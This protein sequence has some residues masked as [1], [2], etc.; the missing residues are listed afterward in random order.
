MSRTEG[1][2]GDPDAVIIGSGPNGLVAACML[3]RAGLD[4]LVL[5]A[6]PSRAGGAVGSEEATRPGFVH[7]VGAGFF[8]WGSLSPAFRNLPLLEHGLRWRWADFESCHPAPDGSY[9]CIAR[10]H[11]RT[12]EH[13]GSPADGKRWRRAAIWYASIEPA[14][15]DLLLRSFPALGAAVRLGPAH[16]ARL[17]S[18]F[19]SSGRGLSERWFTSAAARRVLPSLALHVDVGPDDRFGAALGFMLGMTATTGGYAVPEGGARWIT[20]AL[21]GC[22]QSYGGR[23]RLGARVHQIVVHGGR[24]AAVRITG[25]EEIA[26]RVILADT[27]VAALLLDLVGRQHVPA[28]VADFVRH[29]PRGWGT[30]KVDWAL[31]GAVPWSVE[32]ARASAVV[33][34]GDSVDDLSRFTAAVRAGSLPNH[35]YVV[36]GQQSLADPTRAPPGCHALWA[37]TRV[38]SLIEGG[39][40][41]Q[42]ERHA[43]RIDARIEELAP[44]FRSLILARRVVSPDQLQAMDANLVGGDLGGGSNAWHRQL[45]FRPV[46]PYFRY[47]MPVDGLYLCSS[48]AHPGAGVHG[49]CGFNAA[50]RVLKDLA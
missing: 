30:L 41:A 23:V 17:A 16:L 39:W 8:P 13:F 14:V 49:M 22:L 20:N 24:A 10:D 44:G 26:A 38:P 19:A 25:G 37:Y 35:P 6:H 9:A 50:E 46:F 15:I 11:D 27:D 47:R 3:A 12:A 33:H 7:D 42:A 31:D 21:V 32:A 28:R 40:A 45:L 1:V 36:I 2:R 4:V 43:D 48:Y 5:E 18:V 29:Y 34:A